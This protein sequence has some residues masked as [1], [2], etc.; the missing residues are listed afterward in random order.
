MEDTRKRHLAAFTPSAHRV[1]HH[2]TARRFC[3]LPAKRE[4]GSKHV[5]GMIRTA[6][7][8]KV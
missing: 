1:V 4:G 6:I 5:Q 2:S 8:F 3:F 7:K